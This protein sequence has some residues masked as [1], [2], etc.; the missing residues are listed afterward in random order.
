MP[1]VSHFDIPAD[2]PKR[3]QK[4]YKEVF[5]WKFKK[6]DG[7]M[8][9]WMAKTGTKEP[10]ID[11]GMSKRMPGQ[12]GMTN[13]INVPSIEKFSKKI[14][15]NGGQLIIPKMAIPKVGW[16][17]QCMDTEGNMFGIIEMDEKAE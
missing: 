17:A 9:Y 10:G 7:P 11:G 8:D 3:A 14:M 2:D 4:F 16:F 13:T 5:G 15:E 12:I 1:R 6:W